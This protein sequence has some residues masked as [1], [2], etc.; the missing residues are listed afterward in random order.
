MSTPETPLDAVRL[1]RA[2]ALAAGDGPPDGSV[3]ALLPLVAALVDAP[4]AAVLVRD[5]GHERVHTTLGT[6]GP[7]DAL[8]TAAGFTLSYMDFSWL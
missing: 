5:D 8:L 4:R 3:A 7:D 6:P 1:A 2:A